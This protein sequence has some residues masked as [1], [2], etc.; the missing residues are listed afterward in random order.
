MKQTEAQKRAKQKYED[1]NRERKRYHSLKSSSKTFINNYGSNDDLRMLLD[2]IYNKLNINGTCGIIN[3]GNN[4]T[5]VISSN[6]E[7]YDTC[8]INNDAKE[9]PLVNK[10]IQD[11]LD[12]FN[13]KEQS[14]KLTKSTKN[15]ISKQERLKQIELF[16]KENNI[17]INNKDSLAKAKK[18]Y[19][20]KYE[21]AL[22]YSQKYFK[23]YLEPNK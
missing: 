18:D 21:V 14:K 17:D 7:V 2:L 8:V 15:R 19:A 13:E 20:I 11:K 5:C 1:N 6:N 10:K 16:I 22:R 3:N 9:E 12:K 4:D 23:E